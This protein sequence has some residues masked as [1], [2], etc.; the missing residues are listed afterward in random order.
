MLKRHYV[1]ALVCYIAIP[2]VV[3]AGVRLSLLIDPEMARGTADYVRNFRVL[4]MVATSA[5]WATAGLALVL[6]TLT[7]YLVLKSRQRS[8][9]WLALAVAGPFGFMFITML[10]D[11]SPAPDDLYQHF[12][13]SLKFYWRVP[14]EIVVFISAWVLAYQGVVLKRDLLISFE[15]SSTGTPVQTI[16]ARQ[17]ASSGMYA[18]SEGLEEMY[19]VIL[20][21][22]LW[23][24]FFN[25]VG[26]RF[27]RRASPV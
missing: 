21:Y 4:Q 19:L 10:A 2:V 25:F 26:Q 13:R 18:F 20:L 27:K 3:I 16:I 24:I 22:L 11:R 14:L 12:I 9:L 6:W 5:L 1:I 23:P 17:N 7:C 8:M 15:S